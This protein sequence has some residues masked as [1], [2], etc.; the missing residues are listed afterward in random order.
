[1]S[2][3]ADSNGNDAAV[4]LLQ[5]VVQQA[6]V[7]ATT[8]LVAGLFGA[9]RIDRA[10]KHELLQMQQDAQQL[11]LEVAAEHSQLREAAATALQGVQGSLQAADQAPTGEVVP[12]A[13]EA[14]VVL[15]AAWAPVARMAQ[16]QPPQCQSEQQLPNAF[17]PPHCCSTCAGTMWDAAMQVWAADCQD[18]LLA[19][20]VTSNVLQLGISMQCCQLIKQMV[21][22]LLSSRHGKPGSRRLYTVLTV[23]SPSPAPH[24]SQSGGEISMHRTHKA[25]S[26]TGCAAQQQSLR[27]TS[28]TPPQQLL[29]DCTR[30]LQPQPLSTHDNDRLA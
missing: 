19:G 1:V 16:Q 22:M 11:L 21:G 6:G 27:D 17:A 2:H 26:T 7:A 13:G 12:A 15:A 8:V 3:V 4:Q 14:G 20:T 29:L 25:W 10:P 24:H 23:L 30:K 5:G 28:T 18:T 9:W